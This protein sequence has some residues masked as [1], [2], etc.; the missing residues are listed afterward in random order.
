VCRI[1]HG[2]GNGVNAILRNKVGEFR[3]L[4]A[5]GR[6]LRALDCKLMGQANRPGTMRS[7]GS[8]KN[9]KMNRL[10]DASKLLFALSR[11]T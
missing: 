10:R 5:V 1:D 3:S 7:C 2:L 8:D 9:F 11:Q 6:D 4:N